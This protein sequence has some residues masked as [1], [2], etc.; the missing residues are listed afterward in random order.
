M[1]LIAFIGMMETKEGGGGVNGGGFLE[2]TAKEELVL[3][4]PAAVQ[5]S[6]EQNFKFS[7]V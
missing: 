6:R 5:C 1:E 4:P 7:P 3:F 2:E